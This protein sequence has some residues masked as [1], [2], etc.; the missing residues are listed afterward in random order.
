MGRREEGNVLT[1]ALH[2]KV[3]EPVE[4]SLARATP[5]KRLQRG[6]T[7]DAYFGI[8]FADLPQFHTMFMPRRWELLKFLSEHGA[9][10]VADA[11]LST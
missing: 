7:P 11:M 3:G 9:M 1:H 6:Q 5:W 2:I 4:A 8:G 10:A